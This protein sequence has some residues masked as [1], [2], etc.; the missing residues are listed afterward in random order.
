M[1][2]DPPNSEPPKPRLFSAPGRAP[3]EPAETS[4]PFGWAFEF[5]ANPFP[6]ETGGYDRFEDNKLEAEERLATLRAHCSVERSVNPENPV[7]VVMREVLGT[8]DVRASM[9]CAWGVHVASDL[10]DF[11]HFLTSYA[12]DLYRK[13]VDSPQ[14]NDGD[15]DNSVKNTLIKVRFELMARVDSWKAEARRTVRERTSKTE[16]A[17]SGKVELSKSLRGGKRT[18]PSDAA[19]VLALAAELEMTQD[20]F[21]E[22]CGVSKDSVARLE[23]GKGLGRKT[24]AQVEKRISQH[25]KREISLK[26]V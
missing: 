24:F 4:P 25:C 19:K 2:P 8:I 22:K 14:L 20:E 9:A 26:L 6:P 21:A 13:A 17:A 18:I 16:T 3:G 7:L 5:E 1:H 10:P 12:E 15:A 11:D 23:S